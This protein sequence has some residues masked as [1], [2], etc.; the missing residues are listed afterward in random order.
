MNAYI[1]YFLI[2]L[3]LTVGSAQCMQEEEKPKE[4]HFRFQVSLD[5]GD[6]IFFH[7]T[8]EFLSQPKESNIMIFLSKKH[9]LTN[10]TTGSSAAG[11]SFVLYRLF[12]TLFTLR[13]GVKAV[14]DFSEDFESQNCN[15]NI[16]I[17]TPLS[18]EFRTK[19]GEIANNPLTTI[20]PE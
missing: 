17:A 5:I 3:S 2:L 6:S 12:N 11:Q 9:H 1:L 8:E 20:I 15:I 4:H 19:I 14:I 10:S 7:L 16:T 13:K 18:H